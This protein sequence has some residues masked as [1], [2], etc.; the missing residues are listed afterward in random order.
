MNSCPTIWASDR[1]PGLA[2]A[3]PVLDAVGDPLP[4]DGAGGP[5]AEPV[6]GPPALVVAVGCGA[7]A[8]ESG[9]SGA[10]HPAETTARPTTSA[11]LRDLVSTGLGSCRSARDIPSKTSGRW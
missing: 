11:A 5:D 10:V 4:A 6:P 9:A 2:G 7:G 8:L 1:P 3:V